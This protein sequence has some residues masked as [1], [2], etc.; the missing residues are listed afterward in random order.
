ML[1]WRVELVKNLGVPIATLAM[2]IGVAAACGGGDTEGGLMVELGESG[3]RRSSEEV[4]AEATRRAAR[5]Q[6]NAEAE[7]SPTLKDPG[8]APS[9]TRTEVGRASGTPSA[10][11]T[12]AEV[13]IPTGDDYDPELNMY[14][15]L[16]G[17]GHRAE[18]T[19]QALA[20]AVENGD[21]T[22]V[23]VII[24]GMRFLASNALADLSTIALSELTGEDFG[25]GIAA[26][27]DWMEWYGRNSADFPP[28]EG[29]VGWKVNLLSQIDPA[30]A[31]F[32]MPWALSG[33][34]D[35]TEIVW[36]GVRKD[37]I[38]DLQN[39]PLLSP[40]EAEQAYIRAEDRVFGVSINGEHRA[41]PLRVVNAHEMANDVVG[42]EPIALAY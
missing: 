8:P 20:A 25:Q 10:E 11:P 23:P 2:M 37:G 32:L 18:T 31:E 3:Q 30:F 24:E 1:A 33:E 36:G 16:S 14:R 15:Y 42:G 21:R 40:E 34:I 9:P 26:W 39:P 38:P 28:P 7:P 5:A 22:Q 35:P 4:S 27:D 13:T 17:G 19:V 12:P 41:Y 6:L 29:Y